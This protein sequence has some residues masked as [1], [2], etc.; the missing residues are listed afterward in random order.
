MGSR[1]ERPKRETESSRLVE[2]VKER[3]LKLDVAWVLEMAVSK[4]NT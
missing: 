4:S 3:W 1:A 2:W